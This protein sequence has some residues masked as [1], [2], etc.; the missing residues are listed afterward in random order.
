MIKNS[1]VMV[2]I[3]K[4]IQLFVILSVLFILSV[5]A[6]VSAAGERATA[7]NTG[8]HSPT[9]YTGM[10]ENALVALHYT[11][12]TSGFLF[13]QENNILLGV[14]GANTL[15]KSRDGSTSVGST[16][17]ISGG[18]GDRFSG[19][20]PTTGYAGGNLVLNGGKGSNANFGGAG[21]NILIDAGGG[22]AGFPSG[23]TGN[24]LLGSVRGNVGIGTATPIAKLDVTGTAIL[25]GDVVI[26]LS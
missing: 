5:V 12:T 15:L 1:N 10:L 6:N 18:D 7:L 24:I 2:S 25:R 17:T 8:Y 4:S 14:V 13:L 20:G 11:S 9:L 21:G 26:D 19:S 23:A 3:K 16:L 22:G